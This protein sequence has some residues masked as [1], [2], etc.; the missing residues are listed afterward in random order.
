MNIK[1]RSDYMSYYTEEELKSLGL[2]SYGK[3][4]LISTRS[5]IYSPHTISIGSNVRIDDFCV[6]SGGNGEIRIGSYV[7]IAV[8]CAIFGA[9]GVELKDF[10]TLSSRVSVHSGSDDPSGNYLTNPTI[11]SEFLNVIKGKI[12]LHK[13]VCIGSGSTVLPNVEIGEGSIIGANS[14]VAKD[15][16]E[17][18]VY[19]GVPVRK[20]NTR[21]QG[22]LEL[23][24]KL[25][26]QNEQQ[27][28][29]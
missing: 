17:W 23:E 5:T 26:A 2:S 14:L 29:A 3:N 6:L 15:I 12:T 13:H 20:I 11:P 18:G 27:A 21:Q 19:L 24:K 25:L 28:D 1:I 9:G 16:P 4:V 8:F 22:L 7:H 10:S